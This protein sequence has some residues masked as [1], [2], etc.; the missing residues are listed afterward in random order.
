MIESE[1]PRPNRPQPRARVAL[2]GLSL[3]LSL[4]IASMLTLFGIA[5]LDAIAGYEFGS[6]RLL[7]LAVILMLQNFGMMTL[8]GYLI[9]RM[10]R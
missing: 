8:V 9:A 3:V 4:S 1:Y 6:A 10:S 2:V 7:W 5:L